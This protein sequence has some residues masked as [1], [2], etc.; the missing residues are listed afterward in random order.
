MTHAPDGLTVVVTRP[1]AQSARFIELARA[2][3][4]ECIAYPTLQIEPLSLPVTTLA[5]LRSR[6]WHW[7]IFTSANA[8]GT[9]FQHIAP[10]LAA[11]YAAVGRATARAL[12]LA[13]VHVDARPASATSEGVLALPEF[14][15][16]TG[17]GVVIVKGAGGRE[18][19]REALHSRG[20]HVLELETYRRVPVQPTATMATDLHA[21]L[22]TDKP[23]VVTVTSAEILQSLLD[24]VP[25][26]DD[27]A[28]RRR[29]L[30]VPGARV[31]A[32]AAQLGWQ[33][34]IV[35]AATAEDD[36]M[37]Q[38]TLSVVRGTLPAA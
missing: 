38:A 7:A 27:T 20:A 29:P 4:A 18:L 10:P 23:L 26:A 14:A 25:A 6:R 21:A 16:L 30:V 12:E 32:A 15:D 28:L 5:Q 35:Q 3:G 22:M 8:V 36:A 2:A 33:G 31:A 11:Q 37:M 9:L 13:G 34:P 24:H 1:A 19:L 17:C